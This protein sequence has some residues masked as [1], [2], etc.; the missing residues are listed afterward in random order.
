[1][2]TGWWYLKWNAIEGDL[3]E[4]SD[5]TLEHIADLIK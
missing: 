5:C 3:D 1:M 4:L 2:K